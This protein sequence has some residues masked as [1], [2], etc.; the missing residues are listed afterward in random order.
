MKD[1]VY[2]VASQLVLIYKSYAEINL[3]QD[4]GHPARSSNAPLLDSTCF[5]CR[6]MYEVD[7][8]LNK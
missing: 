2:N 6:Y 7:P 3:V 5:S 4:A 8:T 1:G